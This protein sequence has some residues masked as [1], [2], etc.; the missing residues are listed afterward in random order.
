MQLCTFYVDGL[1]LGVEVDRVQEVIR[2][3]PMTRVP[4]APAVLGGLIN[5]RGQIVT[6]VDLRRR[7]DLSARPDDTPP[8]NVVIRDDD[9]AVSLLVDGIGDV[10]DVASEDWEPRPDTVQGSAREL[11]TGAYKTA[12]RLLLVLDTAG[13]MD[14]AAPEGRAAAA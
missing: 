3:Q 13:A 11:I 4:L 9:G 8:M 5:L 7:L 2:C 6:A 10:V 1:Y 14:I 12:G